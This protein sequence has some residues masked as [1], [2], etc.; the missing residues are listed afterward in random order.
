MVPAFHMKQQFQMS[1]K[2]VTPPP[3]T[4]IR[5]TKKIKVFGSLYLCQLKLW[6]LLISLNYSLKSGWLDKPRKVQAVGITYSVL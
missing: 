3:Q 4:K 1:R 5:E 2:K 6:F